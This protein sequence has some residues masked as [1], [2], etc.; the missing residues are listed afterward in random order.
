MQAFGQYREFL[1]YATLLSAAMSFSISRSLPYFL[2]KF[3]AQERIY[4]TQAA[5][6][7]FL[8]CVFGLGLIVL[9]KSIILAATSFDFIVPLVLYLFFFLNLDFLEFYW[10][11][12]ARSDYVLYY[13]SGRLF[14]RMVTVVLTAY[15]TRNVQTIIYSLIAVEALRFVL[16]LFFTLRHKVIVGGVRWDTLKRQMVFFMPLGIAGVIV[17]FN[18]DIGKLLI[19]TNLGV[20]ALAF[21]VIGTYIAPI[22]NIFRSSVADVIFPEIVAIKTDEPRVALQLWRRATV[23]YCFLLFPMA[24]V[25]FYYADVFIITIFTDAYSPGIPIFMIYL[26]LLMRE[27]FDFNLPLRAMNKNVYTLIGDTLALLLNLGLILLLLDWLGLIGPAVAYVTADLIMAIYLG[28]QVL[29]LT[30]MSLAEMLPWGQL[31]MILFACIV[32]SPI[33]FVGEYIAMN[34]V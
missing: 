25:L 16:V 27:C 31:G 23:L 20:A 24:F 1:L 22:I 10:L 6:F 19:S 30:G 9:G 14:I 32:S 11:A 18:R 5:L 21:Y 7:E 34:E 15:Y 17:A 12:K 13:S 8:F 26:F 3:P 4:V 29:R 28:R 33:L 2:P